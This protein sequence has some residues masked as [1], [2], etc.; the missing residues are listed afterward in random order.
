VDRLRRLLER[1]GLPVRIEGVTPELRLEHMRINSHPGRP[2]P[3]FIDPHVLQRQ[4][5]RHPLN[6]SPAAPPAPATDAGGPLGSL[7]L[8]HS[9]DMAAPSTVQRR[10]ASPVKPP[11]VVVADSTR[12]QTCGRD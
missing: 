9:W 1:V 10:W 7:D 6:F 2:T 12:G 5:R 3:F 8:P 4:P 11:G